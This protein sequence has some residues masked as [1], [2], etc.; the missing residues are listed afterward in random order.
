MI[1]IQTVGNRT[2]QTGQEGKRRE[3]ERAK[4][5]L[6]EVKRLKKDIDSYD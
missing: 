4:G 2:R 1:K 5:D 6:I 3:R